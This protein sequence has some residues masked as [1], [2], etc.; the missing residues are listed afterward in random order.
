MAG[1][2]DNA[3]VSPLLP[4][5]VGYR[6]GGDGAHRLHITA[7]GA[8]TRHQGGLQHV[9]GD[10]GVLADEDHRPAAGILR[11]DAGHGLPHPERH[12][13]RQVLAD[14]TSNTVSAKKFAH[15]VRSLLS[16]ILPLQI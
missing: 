2:E 10:A 3:S 7:H 11:Q 13:R 14:D 4:G 9:G 16:R 5:E 12:L 6:R 15:I 8:D 1:G